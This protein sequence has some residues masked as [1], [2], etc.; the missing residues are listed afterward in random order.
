MPDFELEERFYNEGYKY[1]VSIN[2][3]EKSYHH[4]IC[5]ARQSGLQ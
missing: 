2:S 5:R 1:E 4:N 3:K